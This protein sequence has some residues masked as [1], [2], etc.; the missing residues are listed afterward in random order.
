MT[1]EVVK[2]TTEVVESEYFTKEDYEAWGGP[3][4]YWDRVAESDGF[5]IEGIP[6]TPF[7]GGLIA[8]NCNLMPENLMVKHYAMLGLHRYNMSEGTS[9]ELDRLIKYNKLQNAVSSYYMTLLAYDPSLRQEETFQVRTDERKVNRLDV[10]CSISRPRDKKDEVST[11]ELPTKEPFVPHFYRCAVSDS[12]LFNGELP[13]W[14]SDDALNDTNR[15]YV[16]KES[17]WQATDWIHLYMEL[18]LCANDRASAQRRPDFMS[19]LQILK[20]AIETDIGGM[21]PPNE[22]LKANCANVYITF[23]GLETVPRIDEIGKHVE[24]KAIVRRVISPGFLTLV[25]KHWSGKDTE[26]RS[27]TLKSGENVRRSRKRYRFG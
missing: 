23:K 25:G 21:K 12:T 22:R 10:T 9:F 17:E 14:P 2:N 27:V 13:D 8:R 1:T 7:S 4:V 16:L 3:S 18:L 11:E 20:V 6:T 19:D 26:K 24:R 5:D 15:F